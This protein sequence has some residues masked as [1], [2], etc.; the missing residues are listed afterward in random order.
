[1]LASIF[2]FL[3][4]LFN[5]LELEVQTLLISHLFPVILPKSARFGRFFQQ[6]LL[7]SKHTHTLR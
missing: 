6:A 3:C 2:P 1:M 5:N 4:C 7:A